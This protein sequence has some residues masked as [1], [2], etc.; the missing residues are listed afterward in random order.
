MNGP[1]LDVVTFGEVMA[2]FVAT[3]SGPLES[4]VNFSRAL[5]GAET[6]VAIGLARLGHHVGW[7]GRVGQDHFGR[8]ALAELANNGVDTA[9]VSFDPE[10]ATGFQLKSRADG[11]DPE[12]AYFRRDSAGSR[13]SPSPATDAYISSGRHLHVTGI[14]LA[15]SPSTRAFT[16]RAITIAR[17]SGMTVSFDPNLRPGLWA[18]PEEMIQVTNDVAATADWVLP[19]LAEGR[20]LS[21]LT[22]ADADQVARFYLD[23]GAQRVVVKAAVQGASLHTAAGRWGRR[24]F[25]VEVVDTVGAGDGFAAGLISAHLDGLS[26][27]AALERAA[28]IGALATTSSGDKDGLPDRPALAAFLAEQHLTAALS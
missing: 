16:F 5:A 24:I 10:A 8:F 17:E 19:G 26:V 22:G 20:L 2:M 12:V 28:A 3:E 11:G 4:A 1:V 6:N 25:P 13:L 18:S 7:V 21:G 23:R 15:L 9:A 14:P 27:E